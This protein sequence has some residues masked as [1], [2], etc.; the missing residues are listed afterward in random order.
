MIRERNGDW[1][2]FL[3]RAEGFHNDLGVIYRGWDA[4][5]DKD[6]GATPELAYTD[7]LKKTA[8]KLAM[9]YGITSQEEPE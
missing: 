6:R 5:K 2:V 9:V 3:D 4:S 8:D 1:V 7:L